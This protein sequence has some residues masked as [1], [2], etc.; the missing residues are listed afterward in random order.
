[1]KGSQHIGEQSNRVIV[2]WLGVLADLRAR[3]ILKDPNA[4]IVYLQQAE[5]ALR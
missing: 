4:R 1:M 3:I 2:C 5:A